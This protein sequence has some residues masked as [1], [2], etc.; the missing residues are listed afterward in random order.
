MKLAAAHY[1]AASLD[2]LAAIRE[3]VESSA[4]AAGGD[5]DLVGD[6]VLAVNEA[7]C[8]IIVHGY[9]NRPGSVEVIVEQSDHDIQVRLRDQAPAFDPTSVPTPD[10][11]R[12][13]EM[14]GIGGMGVHMM[15]QFTD[16]INYGQTADGVNELLM[17]KR[18][19]IQS[20]PANQPT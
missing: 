2:D 4:V 16:E 17:V 11:T 6:L 15:R 5:P 8:N 9:Q 13:L 20:E 12:P 3:L 1:T 19:V 7:A 10:I 18:N 14:R